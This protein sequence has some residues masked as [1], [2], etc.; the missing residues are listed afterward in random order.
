VVVIASS[1][2]RLKPSRG[3]MPVERA[4]IIRSF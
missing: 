4:A 3:K 1:A 2:S